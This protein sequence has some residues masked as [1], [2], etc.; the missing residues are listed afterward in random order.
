MREKPFYSTVEAAQES[1]SHVAA[2]QAGISLLSLTFGYLN[3]GAICD[4]PLGEF[5]VTAAIV[6]AALAGLAYYAFSTESMDKYFATVV[7]YA[8][9]FQDSEGVTAPKKDGIVIASLLALFLGSWIWSLVTLITT[10]QCQFC[11]I[12]APFLYYGAAVI[13]TANFVVLGYYLWKVHKTIP[14]NQNWKVLVCL[15]HPVEVMTPIFESAWNSVS[16]AVTV[17]DEFFASNVPWVHTAYHAAYK[18]TR[19]AAMYV[20]KKV[21]AAFSYLWEK[22]KEGYS[23]IKD[24]A[25]KISVP[26]MPALPSLPKFSWPKIFGKTEEEPLLPGARSG[27]PG[28]RTD[29]IPAAA[30]GFFPTF[31][32]TKGSPQGQR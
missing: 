9:G 30:T 4:A 32:W 2:A 31:G 20:F 12:S 6:A 29:E 26:S 13:A 19:D 14:E 28:K 27:T 21:H 10:T 7:R 25:S 3:R 17:T 18:Y 11:Q 1:F 22:T 5:L 24:W 23:K 16:S 15:N 8:A